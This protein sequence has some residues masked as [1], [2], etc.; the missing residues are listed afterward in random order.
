MPPNRLAE[1]RKLISGLN[2]PGLFSPLAHIEKAI[3]R[4]YSLLTAY[5]R[6]RLGELLHE[7][8]DKIRYADEILA[9]IQN[10]RKMKHVR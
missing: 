5:E 8:R 1:K 2:Q 3:E 7:A 9:P 10:R 4:E 6:R